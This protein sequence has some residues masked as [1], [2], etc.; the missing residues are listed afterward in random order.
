MHCHLNQQMWKRF[1]SAAL[2]NPQAK[3]SD[4]SRQSHQHKRDNFHSLCRSHSLITCWSSK[5][6]PPPS[7][8]TENP[9]QTA[10][11][12]DVNWSKLEENLTTWVSF[13]CVLSICLW[14]T[15]YYS[16]L[17]FMQDWS[18]E[19]NILSATELKNKSSLYL[20]VDLKKITHPQLLRLS[21][22]A[23]DS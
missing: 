9:P 21:S 23:G 7:L 17:T 22:L 16:F 1:P 6:S 19:L 12:R 11:L 14:V 8:P 20:L 10:I 13:L 3:V 18:S 4:S 5:D 2:L 15:R